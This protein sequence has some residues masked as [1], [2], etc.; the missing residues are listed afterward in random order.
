VIDRNALLAA[1]K[2]G[3]EHELG[4]LSRARLPG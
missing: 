2:R 4:S 1:L 3:L